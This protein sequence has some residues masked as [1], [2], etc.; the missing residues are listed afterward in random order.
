MRP[1]SKVDVYSWHA[2][3]GEAGGRMSDTTIHISVD[4]NT[5]S[6]SKDKLYKILDIPA[7][8]EYNADE[9]SKALDKR[10]RDMLV[11]FLAIA[12]EANIK[13]DEDEV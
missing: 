13:E 1:Y 12:N 2:F 4:G 9:I 6:F 8:T 10:A 3:I 11:A 5:F 7:D